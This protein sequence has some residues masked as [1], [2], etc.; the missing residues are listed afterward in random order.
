MHKVGMIL[1]CI[2]TTIFAGFFKDKML[3]FKNL[4]DLR[5]MMPTSIVAAIF[6]RPLQEASTYVTQRQL[7]RRF[8]VKLILCYK[9]KCKVRSKFLKN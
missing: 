9:Q 8:A 5:R 7:M 1:I 2:H 4:Q 3:Q 6:K